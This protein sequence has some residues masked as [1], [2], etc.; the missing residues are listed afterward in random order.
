M[1]KYFLTVTA[2]AKTGKDEKFR[3]W[4]KNIHIPELLQ[5]PGFIKGTRYYSENP[6]V[7]TPYLTVYEIESSDIQ[8]T[9]GK[10]QER[11]KDMTR[12]EAID[13]HSVSLQIYRMLD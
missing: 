3:N 10:M 13:E 4:Y 9:M 11:S 2:S 8:V 7:K 5:I 12:S 1:N 6:E